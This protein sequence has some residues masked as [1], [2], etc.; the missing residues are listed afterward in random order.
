MRK[1]ND[2]ETHIEA[3]ETLGCSNTT[4][5]NETEA[6]AGEDAHPTYAVTGDGYAN[7]TPKIL[8]SLSDAET[9]GK[10]RRTPRIAT[11]VHADTG[12]ETFTHIDH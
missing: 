3:R 7:A 8:L 12:D 5:K 6:F 4:Q 2:D 1:E 10:I 9:F 11:D